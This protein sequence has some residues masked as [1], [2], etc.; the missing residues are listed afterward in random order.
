MH[1]KLN[2][3]IIIMAVAGYCSASA[4]AVAA[5]AEGARAHAIKER[6]ASH[7]GSSKLKSLAG[8]KSTLGATRSV[9]SSQLM[10]GQWFSSSSTGAVNG[11][12]PVIVD[13]ST[14][15]TPD[16]VDVSKKTG[17]AGELQAGDQI[18]ISWLLKDTEGDT[19]TDNTATISTIKWYRSDDASGTNKS[20]IS[21]ASGKIDYTITNDDANKYIG[22]EI[23][24]TTQTGVPTTG[25]KISFNDISTIDPNDDIPDGPVIDSTLKVAI[26]DSLDTAYATDLT[27]SADTTIKTG[28]TYVAILYQ[29]KDKDGKYSP[30]SD[31]DVTSKYDY[32][33]SFTG[34][35]ATT[36]TAGG[37][38]TVTNANITIPA[39]NAE[40]KTVF[41]SA[42]DDGV[43]GYGLQVQYRIK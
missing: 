16:S 11:T 5:P 14:D 21:A 4:L 26:F 43:Q 24:P 1:F 29:D 22:I 40:A 3:L 19:D 27:T 38:S 31:T 23:T 13:N 17:E 15:N 25:A 37:E 10:S 41:A 28:D 8:K 6:L 18:E 39:T 12:V 36:K 35:S 20:E 30:A 2:K 32:K 7:A 33:W 42:G 34:T 9:G